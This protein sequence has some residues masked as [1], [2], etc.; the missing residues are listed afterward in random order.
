MGG[1][2]PFCPGAF[3]HFGGLQCGGVPAPVG[4]FHHRGLQRG[5]MHHHINI[6]RQLQ[7]DLSRCR[8]AKDGQRFSGCCGAKIVS[9]V[10]YPPIFQRHAI[11]LLQLLKPRTAWHPFRFQPGGIQQTGFVMLFNAIAKT[12]HRMAQRPGADTKLT[13]VQRP[14]RLNL[15]DGQR[16]VGVGTADRQRRLDKGL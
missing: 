7:R 10:D 6:G 13:V 11:T 12:L 16:V 8:I 9:T 4:F 14:A 3:C 15:N 1:D 5:F 2:Q